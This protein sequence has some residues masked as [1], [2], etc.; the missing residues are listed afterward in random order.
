MGETGLTVAGV[1]RLLW[2]RVH[3]FGRG[4]DATEEHEDIFLVLAGRFEPTARNNPEPSE[5]GI[6]H[7]FRWWSVAALKAATSD[8]FA[9]R[10][11]PG[12]VEELLSKGPPSQPIPLDE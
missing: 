10:S 9:P 11:L 6:F 5:V 2:R 8:Q 1:P 4:G 12:L 7:E 3:G